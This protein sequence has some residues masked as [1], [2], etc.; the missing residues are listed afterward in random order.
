MT[1]K[2]IEFIKIEI[3]KKYKTLLQFRG[4]R[5]KVKQMIDSLKVAMVYKGLNIYTLYNPFK[6]KIVYFFAFKKDGYL[7]M[8]KDTIDEI[9]NIIDF[10]YLKSKKEFDEFL[11]LQVS[12]NE[13]LSLYNKILAD[14]NIEISKI[15]SSIADLEE[16]IYV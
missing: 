3:D 14:W 15:E 13:I 6:N 11:K 4:I 2:D 16:K 10:Y 1:D 12:L 7:A 5:E 9:K 8:I